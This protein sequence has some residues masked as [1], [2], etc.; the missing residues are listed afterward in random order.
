MNKKITRRV[1]LGT[2]IGGL[3]AVPFVA[4]RFRRHEQITDQFAEEWKRL[5]TR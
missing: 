2:V 4:S 1:V 5:V 3:V